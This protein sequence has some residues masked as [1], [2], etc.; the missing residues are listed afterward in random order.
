MIEAILL[1]QQNKMLNTN[2]KLLILEHTLILRTSCILY[3]KVC[4][5]HNYT[6][7]SYLQSTDWPDKYN[8]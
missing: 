8:S 5:L 7:M 1:Q 2:Y 3:F 6:E 4:I